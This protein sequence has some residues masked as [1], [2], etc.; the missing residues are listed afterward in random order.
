[1]DR[2]L[3]DGARGFRRTLGS[4]FCLFLLPVSLLGQ[5]S[6]QTVPP[7][8]Q[9]QRSLMDSAGTRSVTIDTSGVNM[10]RLAIVCGFTAGSIAMIHIY[11]Q[12]GWWRNNRTSFH[13]QEDLIYGRSVDKLGHM[14]GANVLTFVF[15]KALQW[16]N[17][18]E[19]SSL[20]YGA[21]TSLLFQTYIEVEDG[22]SEWG[23][24]RVDF[25]SDVVGAFY[26][27]AQHYAPVLQSFNFKFSYRPSA[28]INE[29]G[30][31]GFKGQKHLM[32]DDYEGQTIWLGISVN[33]L[34]PQSLEPYWPD[35]LGIAVG[36]GAR[37]IAKANPYSVLYLSLDYDLRKI[38]PRNTWFLTILGE[39]LN[40]IHLPA[41]AVKISPN[42]V[43]YGIYF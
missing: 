37:D 1:M 39:A 36:Y 11:Q 4:F 9:I 41:P 10:G 6:L 19:R 17:L 30:G 25:A 5:D 12:N 18:Q 26:P 42:V 2:L 3:D 8:S 29:G 14:Y 15:S 23:F 40:F 43:W 33:D 31:I 13:F 38:I 22:F 7:V 21:G 24:D 20:W 16:A 35:W 34:L 27:V 32:F 28:L